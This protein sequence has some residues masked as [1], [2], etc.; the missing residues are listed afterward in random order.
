[1]SGG[2]PPRTAVSTFCSVLSLLTYRLLTFS[3]GCWFWY[4][5]TRCAN[6]LASGPVQPSQIWTVVAPPPPPL[7][8]SV[9]QAA[10][11]R[12]SV[13]S[14]ASGAAMVTRSRC[15][16]ILPSTSRPA[17]RRPQFGDN[18]DSVT[19]HAGRRP[20]PGDWHRRWRP[21]LH[22][23]VM[24]PAIL[25]T[26]PCGVKPFAPPVLAMSRPGSP[27]VTDNFRPRYGAVTGQPA[28]LAGRA[29]GHEPGLGLRCRESLRALA[30]KPGRWNTTEL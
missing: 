4:S 21:K 27:D 29:P 2:L 19:T 7:P 24:F 16:A 6:A 30:R 8:L 25:C 23:V 3:P 14:A 10:S 26:Q 13:A 15:L 11:P 1:M 5:V 28:R 9:P 22:E 12:D 18:Q 17:R 20:K